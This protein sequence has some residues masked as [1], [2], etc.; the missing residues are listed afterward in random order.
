MTSLVLHDYFRSSASFRVR[1]AMNLKGL[2]YE[3]VEVSLIAGDQRSDAYLEQNAQG[4]VPMLVVDGEPI[5][6]SMA[7]IDWLDRAYPEPRL[8]PDEPMPRAVAL[9]R[10]QVIASDI[11]PLNNLRVLKYLTKDLGLNEQTKDRWIATW[12]AQG[13]EALEAMAGEGRYLGG[14]APGIAD[15]CLVPQMYNAR[16]FEVP[17]DDYPR[18]VEIDAACMELEAFQRAHPD[19]VKP[20]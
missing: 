3:R 1:I 16:R 11:H 12:I 18:L 15:C 19:A 9:A 4:F 20:A 6:Q 8:I 17:L 2:E 5:I 13:F 7:I 10:A 14:D